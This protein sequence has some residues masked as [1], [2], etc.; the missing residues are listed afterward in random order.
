MY[1]LIIDYFRKKKE[2][3]KVPN[4]DLLPS[5]KQQEGVRKHLELHEEAP[6]SLY[7]SLN[8]L[9]EF[10]IFEDKFQTFEKTSQNPINAKKG[11]KNV[12]EGNSYKLQNEAE[13]E[14]KGELDINYSNMLKITPEISMQSESGKNKS[15]TSHQMATQS[16][17]I[18]SELSSTD[19]ILMQK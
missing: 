7:L 13:K 4:L 10:N 15:R 12:K 19:L 17:G 1:L 11:T 3:E 9:E 8:Q 6:G 2:E 16:I 14:N 5:R 18:Q